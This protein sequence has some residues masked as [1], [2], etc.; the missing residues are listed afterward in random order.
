LSETAATI[1]NIAAFLNSTLRVKR[2]RDASVNGLQVRSR[3]RRVIRTVGFAVDAC[4]STFEQAD[5]ENVDMLVVHHGIKW[6][7]QKDRELEFRRTAFLKRRNIAL[8]AVH[9]PLD[10]HQEYGNN[11]QLC[12]MLGVRDLQR[13]GRYHGIKIGYAGMFNRATSLSMV[14]KRMSKGLGAPCR[15]LPFGRDR[16]HSIGVISGGGG[17]ML[18]DAHELRLDCFIIGEA[19]LAVYNAAR[20]YGM[21]LL[22]G[23][24]Y[25]TET[26]GVRALMPL[27]EKTFGVRTVFIDDPKDL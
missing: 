17:G 21:N 4:L 27:I 22:I 9:L 6:R 10:L 15:I 19:D 16:I 25:A 2:I 14:A 11:M 12:R 3:K 23:G 18:K 13:F 5:H 7:P 24:H 1:S 8:Y 20:E 26:V